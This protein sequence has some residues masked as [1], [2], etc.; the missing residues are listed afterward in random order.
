MLRPIVITVLLLVAMAA[1]PGCSHQ[2]D[3]SAAR[4]HTAMAAQR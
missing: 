4:L 2:H 3:K 1:A